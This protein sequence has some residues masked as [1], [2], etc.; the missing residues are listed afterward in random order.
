[1]GQLTIHIEDARGFVNPA[2]VRVALYEAVTLRLD[3]GGEDLSALRG[4]LESVVKKSARLIG[5]FEVLL[6]CDAVC[7]RLDSERGESA[8]NTA[9]DV[10]RGALS[11]AGLG[12]NYEWSHSWRQ[13]RRG[14]PFVN[15]STEGKLRAAH[16]RPFRKFGDKAIA[17]VKKLA[18]AGDDDAKATMKDLAEGWRTAGAQMDHHLATFGAEEVCR[19]MGLSYPSREWLDADEVAPVDGAVA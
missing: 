13:E 17:D 19:R 4:L 1:M 11:R 18:D 3:A 5:K 2:S 14:G 7:L 12:Y 15:I 8:S 10:F 9:S 6:A 16:E